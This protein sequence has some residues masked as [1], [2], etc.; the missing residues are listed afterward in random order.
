VLD[1]L[2]IMNGPDISVRAILD[3]LSLPVQHSHARGNGGMLHV[4]SYT[5]SLVYLPK[6][7]LKRTLPKEE[8]HAA[9]ILC[10]LPTILAERI[11]NNHGDLLGIPVTVLSHADQWQ[12]GEHYYANYA[13]CETVTVRT[14]WFMERMV[15]LEPLEPFSGSVNYTMASRRLAVTS[16]TFQS[17]YFGSINHTI[18]QSIFFGSINHT[19]RHRF[20]MKC[21]I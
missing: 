7:D 20:H 9:F 15:T 2:A 13:I 19:I 12:V 4:I 5:I 17:I 14:T 21:I 6:E 18:F 3:G 11:G 10:W 8:K 1:D 16:I